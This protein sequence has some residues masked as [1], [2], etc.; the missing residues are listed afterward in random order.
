MTAENKLEKIKAD[1]FSDD[2]DKIKNA[3]NHLFN[4]GGKENIDYLLGLLDH[5][6]SSIRNAVALTFR[7]NKFNEAVEPLFKSINKEENKNYRGTMVYA[8]Q[9][10]DCSHKLQEIFKLLFYGNY[11][12]KMGVLTILEEQKFEFT[13]DDL[14]VIQNMW[15]DFNTNPYNYPNHEGMKDLIHGNVEGYL[16]YLKNK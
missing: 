9:M 3:T 1:I 4:L 12:V 14:I 2:W 15:A 10:L 7:D 6:D 8:L 16:S 5:K 13:K 11:E